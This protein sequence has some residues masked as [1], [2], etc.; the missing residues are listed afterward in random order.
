[1]KPRVLV[2]GGSPEQKAALSKELRGTYECGE[3]PGS[4]QVLTA[5]NEG[6]WQVALVDCDPWPGS[7]GLD[8][9]QS[10]RE[11]SPGTFRLLITRHTLSGWAAD[12][13]RLGQP[14]AVVDARDS[15]YLVTLVRTLAALLSPPP[16]PPEVEPPRAPWI[17]HAPASIEFVARLREL[18]E[19]ERVVFL[20]G[21][22]GSEH[23]RA[24]AILRTWRSE[25]Q[26]RGS[27]RRTRAG[28]AVAVLRVP[29]LR[30]R[31][32]DL[33]G[34][35]HECLVEFACAHRQPVKQLAPGLL[36]DLVQ[37]E[38]FGNVAELQATLR[39]ACKRAGSHPLLSAGDLPHSR[40]PAPHPS[41]V[42]KDHGQ[43]DCM[44]RQLRTAGHVTGAAKLEGCTRAN[45]IRMMR[46]LGILRAD[47]TTDSEAAEQAGPPD[48]PPR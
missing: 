21:E 19:S 7:S 26:A 42:A 27:R 4:E 20:H 24:A 29:S 36:T 25:W 43:T 5:L 11:A 30:E 8:V 39:H 3:A 37:R 23:S 44:L 15:G 38:W 10:L 13:S 34:L 6:P 45:Y 28:S 12:I 31:P 2:V 18:A 35:A 41:Q 48:D 14:H 17:A 46:R 33:P 1:M 47:V 40:E 22:N 32:Q 9:L 16:E